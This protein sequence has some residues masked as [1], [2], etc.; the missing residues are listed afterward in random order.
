[1]KREKFIKGCLAAGL[2]IA[3]P[4]TLLAKA[5]RNFRVGQGFLVK[6]GM[7]R[8]EKQ[9]SLFEGD[10]FMTKIST[11]D[12]D[13]D[14]YVF[15]STRLKEGGP[16]THVHFEQDEWWYVLK[17]EFQIK[18]GDTIHEAKAGDSVFG[19]RNVPHAF[20]KIGEG[21]A[22]LLMIFQPAGK[23]EECFTKIANGATKGMTEEQMDEFRMQ[24]GHKKT[25]PPMKVWKKW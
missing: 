5:V 19:P 12:T 4:V 17:G 15:E 7:D 24:H 10:T 20:T 11:K 25:G 21:E 3:S 6:S 2:M 23:M 18:V 16:N 22:K 14:M 1:M 8:F 9:L 13:G